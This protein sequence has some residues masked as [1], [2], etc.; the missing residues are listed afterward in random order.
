M[1][2]RRSEDSLLVMD[3]QIQR[4]RSA[5]VETL[6]SLMRGIMPM[7]DYGSQDRTARVRTF[8]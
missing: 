3:A 2:G 1:A 4:Q 6:S 5:A 8:G 7:L